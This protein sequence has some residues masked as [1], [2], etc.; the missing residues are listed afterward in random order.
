MRHYVQGYKDHYRKRGA[1]RSFLVCMVKYQSNTV[2]D[3][4]MRNDIFC[5]VHIH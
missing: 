4:D 5:G 1:E 3:A 2:I